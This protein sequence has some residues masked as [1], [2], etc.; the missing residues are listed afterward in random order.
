MSPPRCRRATLTPGASYK[1]SVQKKDR[2]GGNNAQRDNDPERDSRA[3]R[4]APGEPGLTGW[5]SHEPRESFVPVSFD[6]VI[7]HRAS[8]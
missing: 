5:A 4:N 3:N 2:D 6:Q 8:A 1:S 7:D